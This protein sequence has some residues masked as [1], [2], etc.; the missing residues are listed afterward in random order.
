MTIVITSVETKFP[1]QESLSF[2]LHL[3][4]KMEMKTER[5]YEL[6]IIAI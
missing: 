3:K 5:V 6:Y 2:L 4:G 1:A